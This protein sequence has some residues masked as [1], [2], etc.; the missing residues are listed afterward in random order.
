MSHLDSLSST[1]APVATPAVLSIAGSDS[2]AGAGLQADLKT[3]AALGVYACTVVTAITA[4]N[5][6]GVRHSWPVSEEQ[7]RAQL[8]SIDSDIELAAIK[9]G[10]LGNA[11][12]V[13]ALAD[14]LE[15]RQDEDRVCPVVL[16]PVLVSSSGHRLLDDEGLTLLKRRLLPFVSLLTPNLPEVAALLGEPEAPVDTPLMGERLLALLPAE[17]AAILIKGG[18][19]DGNECVDWLFEKHDGGQYRL[20]KFRAE[21]IVSNNN[22]GTGCT[23]A[24]AIAACLAYQVPL[25]DA[26][27]EAKQFLSGALYHADQLSIGNRQQSES[28][29]GHGP[30]HHFYRQWPGVEAV[31]AESNAGFEQE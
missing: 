30:L 20:E 23:L 16:D 21:R 24:S 26:V 31:A 7:L 22:H 14:W 8:D 12:L 5:T 25:G 17:R 4:Q 13:A 9:I 27:A 2:C 1:P 11:S 29:R 10:M 3:C 18:H 15:R 6:Q 19:S 28:Y